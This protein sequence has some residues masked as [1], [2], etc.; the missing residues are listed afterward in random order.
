MHYNCLL[1][2]SPT[3]D[4]GEAVS[5]IDPSSNWWHPNWMAHPNDI[6]AA[7]QTLRPDRFAL[8]SQSHALEYNGRLLCRYSLSH[9]MANPDS[10]HPN[11]MWAQAKWICRMTMK[12]PSPNRSA[13]SMLFR[14]AFCVLSPSSIRLCL[15]HLKNL[16]LTL[17]HTHFD[18]LMHT[19]DTQ[20]IRCDDEMLQCD[21][22]GPACTRLR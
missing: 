3:M 11:G 12:C 17:T 1:L 6:V 7:P 5:N 15:C 4:T 18:L 14:I 20:F 9:N 10:C 22:F 16:T 8:V 19:Q 21:S 2:A 13:K